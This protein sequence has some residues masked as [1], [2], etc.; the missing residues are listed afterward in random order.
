MNFKLAELFGNGMIL[1]RD[2][3]VHVYGQ[4]FKA[5]NIEVD[6][7][8][9]H[10]SQYCVPGEF[11]I[12][13]P[14]HKKGKQ[15][16]MTITSGEDT[17]TLQD[18]FCG[19][20]W[21]AG[22]QSNMCMF[23]QYTAEYRAGEKV[24]FSEDIRLYSVGRNVLGSREEYPCGYEWAYNA[25]TAWDGC[26][27]NNAP[28]FSAIGYYFAQVLQNELDVPIGIINC[29]AGGSSIFCWMPKEAM[30]ANPAIASVY[31]DYLRQMSQV[32]KAEA[33]KKYTAYLDSVKEDWYNEAYLAGT[34]GECPVVYYQELGP[35]SYTQPSALY[36]SMYKK[37]GQFTVRGMIWY[38]GEADTFSERSNLYE[39]AMESLLA[40][41]K[42]NA[43]QDEYAFHYVQLAPYHED[44]IQD[45]EGICN[46][47][48]EFHLN[49]REC[50]MIT[51]GD[52]SGHED[53]HP[54]IKKPLGQRLANAACALTYAM[55]R[56]YT[57]P[58]AENACY[59]D[60][61]IDVSFLHGEGLTIDPSCGTLEIEYAD[62]TIEAAEG[63]VEQ[64]RLV[65][66]CSKKNPVAIRYGWCTYYQIGMYNR[67][68]LPAS[69]FRLEI[70]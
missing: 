32:D 39:S 12:T 67:A 59:R 41:L 47:Q 46:A 48:R 40:S 22:G 7:D 37:I 15:L 64:D 27:Q 38:Q 10:G 2:M 29:N 52:C 62:G 23:L 42:F 35:Y 31:T 50:G 25:D 61:R 68:K 24:N 21:V 1:Q 28:F 6:F 13:L 66:L 55:P 70:H 63:S 34:G 65:V 3:P 4:A 69:L 56:E 18:I 53:I 17:V 11:C 51:S 8:G 43:D 20:V 19:E 5:G 30:E 26:N 14:P 60:D 58:I 44:S 33:K 49:H 57:G 36:Q 9:S 16:S 45:W 54:A